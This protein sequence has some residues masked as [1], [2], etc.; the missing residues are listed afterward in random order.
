MYLYGRVCAREREREKRESECMYVC[1]CTNDFGAGVRAD[2]Y[3]CIDICLPMHMHIQ[4]W[5]GFN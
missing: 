2:T 5:G 4:I 3:T 1:L